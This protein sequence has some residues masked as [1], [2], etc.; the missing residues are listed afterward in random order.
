MKFRA[1]V[2]VESRRPLVID[3]IESASLRF[4]Q[5]LVKLFC[6]SICGAQINEIEAVK[7]P[8]RFLPHLLGHE[9]TGEV[10][11]CGEG[12]TTVAPGNRVVLHWRRGSGLQAPTP[13]YKSDRF[14]KVNAG[15]LT[16]FNEYA[17]VSENRVTVIPDAEKSYVKFTQIHPVLDNKNQTLKEP[18]AFQVNTSIM[19]CLVKAI[20]LA[21]GIGLYIYAGEDLPEQDDKPEKTIECNNQN[22]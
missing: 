17:I 19:R 15:W 2:L 16:T 4:G 9:G 14:G 3:E 18:N 21:T 13:E 12:V 6:S 1:A 20:A 7:G 22:R 5:V 8:D 11:E 10:L